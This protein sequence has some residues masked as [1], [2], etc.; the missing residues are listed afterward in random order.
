MNG[1]T[2]RAK[3]LLRTRVLTDSHKCNI[4]CNSLRTEETHNEENFQYQLTFLSHE[5]IMLN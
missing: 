2:A 4:F 3:E 1:L 5:N